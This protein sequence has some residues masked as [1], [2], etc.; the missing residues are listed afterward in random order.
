MQQPRILTL[1]PQRLLGKSLAMSVA[2]N[3]TGLLW[4]S[5]APRIKEI[6]HRM[7]ANRIS[8]Q[9]YPGDYFN[10]FQPQRSFV[11]WAAVSVASYEGQPADL[12]EF[13]LQGGLYAVFDYQGLSSDPSIFQFIYGEWLPQSDYQLD[14]RP[15]F[16]LLGAKYR[17]EDPLS[18]EE[19]WIPI[20]SE[21]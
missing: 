5:F 21:D 6:Q 1:A 8:L 19:I 18:E 4:Q 3:K 20:R 17:N 7:D 14:D 12:E 16:E 15:H 2:E 13:Q 9:V 11:K 10:Q